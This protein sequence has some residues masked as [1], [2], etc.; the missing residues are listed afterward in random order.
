[1]A[2]WLWRWHSVNMAD[3]GGDA[4]INWLWNFTFAIVLYSRDGPK[5]GFQL[6]EMLLLNRHQNVTTLI[7]V[8]SARMSAHVY[9]RLGCGEV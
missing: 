8:T 3:C 4:D 2:G 7:E 9:V 5:V 1:M 6:V